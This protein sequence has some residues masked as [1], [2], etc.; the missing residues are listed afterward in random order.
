MTFNRLMNTAAGGL[1]V[2]QL[3]IATAGNNVANYKVPGYNR[4]HVV[5]TENVTTKSAAG[6]IGNGV[7]ATRIN[8]E[9]S[10]FVVTQLRIAQQRG[11]ELTELHQQISQIDNLLA[12]STTDISASI[13]QF[14]TSF[15][16]VVSDAADIPARQGVL[17]QARNMV[18]RFNNANNYFRELD[19]TVNFMVTENVAQIN[20]YVAQIAEL[21]RQ[22]TQMRGS[23]NAEPND[24]LDQRDQ[25]V[26]D[27]NKI[28]GVT[29]TQQDGD[30]YNVSF[31]GGL[32]LVQGRT[33]YSV[34][35]IPSSADPA[36]TTIG[37]DGGNGTPT[38]I[39]EKGLLGVLGGVLRFR[40]EALDTARNQLGQLALVLADNLNKVNQAGFDLK[41]ILNGPAF[42]A[43]GGP[44]VMSNS[45]NTGGATLTAAYGTNT[46]LVKASDYKLQAVAGQWQI[47]RL[48]D[49]FV[50][51]QAF[52]PTFTVD[53]VDI[54]VAGA[55]ANGDS[56]IVKP[57]SNTAS[58]LTLLITDPSLI[59][60]AEA[61]VS[62]T[63][64]PPRPVGAGGV[65]DSRNAQKFLDLQTQNLVDNKT[66]FIGAYASLVSDVGT[67]TVTVKT[68]NTAQSNI[69]K[70]LTAEQQIISGVNLNEEYIAIQQFEQYYI[71]NSKTIQAASTMFD[72]LVSIR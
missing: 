51:T 71:A 65:S 34:A 4:Q 64:P 60:A 9:F 18:A 69:I 33:A 24:L 32:S 47:T 20:R 70:Q 21:N 59:A 31:S 30:A 62:A 6:Y 19:T 28:I 41:G 40:T 67:K 12:R 22:I 25:T 16:N 44:N 13:Q 35:A 43:Y 7:L 29:V 38:E 45:R 52:A 49:G 5:L 55:P 27:L 17:G 63:P 3:S 50:S 56:F 11:S 57:V 42:F 48:S 8:R 37:Y 10:E 2:A 72:A 58:A 46:S 39:P 1:N 23:A 36:R 54:T 15:E 61:A 68:D 53:G 14:F 66:T 26:D